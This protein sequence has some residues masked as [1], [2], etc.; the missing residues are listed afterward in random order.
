MATIEH[1]L[2]VKTRTTRQAH[3]LEEAFA[4]ADRRTE[5]VRPSSFVT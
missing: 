1:R 3:L 2:F 4:R 5:P